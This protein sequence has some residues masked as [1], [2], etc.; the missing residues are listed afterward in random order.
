MKTHSSFKLA[1]G[2][3]EKPQDHRVVVLGASPKPWRYANQAVRLL[4]EQGYQVLPVHPKI[5]QIEGLSVTHDLKAIRHR[6]HT[7]TVYI[8][9]ERTRPLIQSILRLRP[10]RVI[11]NPGT[12]SEEFEN[13][14]HEHRIPF[15]HACTLVLLRT[16]QF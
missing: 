3:P 12:E 5:A 6:I 4:I 9:P 13:Q 2:H 10:G 7:L 14:L 8:G 11:L 15:L 16:N 1:H